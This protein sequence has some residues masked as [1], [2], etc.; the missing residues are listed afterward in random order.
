[1]HYG[2]A[3]SPDQFFAS[4]VTVILDGQGQWVLRY[5]SDQIT[6]LYGH[7]QDVLDDLALLLP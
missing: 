4:R 2:A 1:M 3:D 5:G 6:S 7:A